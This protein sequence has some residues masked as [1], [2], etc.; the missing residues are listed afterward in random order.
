MDRR[1]IPILLLLYILIVGGCGDSP[2]PTGLRVAV[3]GLDGAT[4]DLI[5]PWIEEGLLPNLAALRES[6]CS[7]DLFSVIPPLSAP[8]WTSAVTGVNP[9]KHGIFDFDLVDRKRF[10]TV[11]VTSLDRKAKAAWEYMTESKRRSVVISVP[12]TSPPDSINGIMISGFPHHTHGGSITW[13]DSLEADLFGWRLDRYGEYLPE[14]GDDAFLNNLIATRSARARVALDFYKNED[15]ELFWAVFMGT[16]KVQ[17]FFW[18]FMDPEGQVVDPERRAKYEEAIRDFWIET[19]RIVGEFVEATDDST[20]LFV[21]SD[22]GFM[23][24]TRE[25]QVLRWLWEEGFCEIDPRDSDV[26]YFTHL[27]GRVTINRSDLFPH[28]TVEPGVEYDSLVAELKRKLLAV[29]DPENGNRVISVVYQKDEIYSGPFIDDAPDLVF[30]PERDYFFGR[31]SPFDQGGVF[32]TPSYTFSAYHDPRG[33]FFAKGPHVRVG[34]NVGELQLID[35][36][37]T[38]LRLLGETIPEE[39]DGSPMGSPFAASLDS[40]AP[41]RIG[42]RPIERDVDASY[43]DDYRKNLTAV[44]YLR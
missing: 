10:A 25:F 36:V 33:I 15:W 21:L 3:I 29:R 39:M 19:D 17:H 37:P 23:R 13:P 20:V 44:P 7:G 35:L 42:G 38:V 14:D 31:G 6:G 2:Q 12:I 8:A 9:A 30:L 34:E 27:G 28:G 5:D 32:K 18:K 24:V 4:Y 43:I 22:H 41:V 40:I 26:L 16:D 1:L 11:P